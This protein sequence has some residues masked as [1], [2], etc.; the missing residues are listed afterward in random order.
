MSKQVPMLPGK[1][2]RSLPMALRIVCMLVFAAVL[3][4]IGLFLILRGSVA[5]PFPTA[6]T[7]SEYLTAKEDSVFVDGAT[8]TPAPITPL[9]ETA[10]TPIATDNRIAVSVYSTL[11]LGDD[12]SAVAA[13]QQKLMDLGYMESDEPGTYYNESTANAVMLFQRASNMEQTGT[14]TAALQ[15]ILFSGTAQEYRIK[16]NDDGPDVKSIQRQ[17]SDLGYYTDRITG[18]YG[19]LTEEAVMRFQSKNG[20][21]ADGQITRD[22]WDL[23][24]S[25]DAVPI[26]TPAPTPSPTPTPKPTK[27]PTPKPTATPK[28]TNTPKPTRTPKPTNTPKPSATAKP[29]GSASSTITPK[30]TKTPKPTNTPKPTKT[31]KPTATPKPTKTPKPTA[32]PKPTN[33]PNPTAKPT[34]DLTQY[35]N[36]ASGVIKCAQNQLGDPYILGD[37]GPDSFDCSGLVHYCLNKC[38]VKVSRRNAYTYSNNDQWERIDSVDDLKKGDLLFFK[39]DTSS[40]VNHAAIYIGGKSFI[41]ASASKGMVVQS[42]F[43]SYWYR[44]FVCGRRVFH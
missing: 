18:Y 3:V 24:Y 11:Q 4:G 39:S 38:G 32:T 28:S 16:L 29:T 12:N 34:A 7:A 14:A 26:A 21:N 13:L 44:N 33:T 22:D 25:D 31:P 5:S 27:S 10:A 35:E 15:E 30:P 2:R 19:P 37:E 43:S 41:H 1:K 17:L 6:N 36:S 9:P 20:M 42:S 8:P 40:K 23:L